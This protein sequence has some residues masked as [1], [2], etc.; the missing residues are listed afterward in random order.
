[1][2]HKYTLARA[3]V[4]LHTSVARVCTLHVGLTSTAPK[5]DAAPENA[6]TE[7]D[8]GFHCDIV[9]VGR[10]N[11]LKANLAFGSFK[12]NMFSRLLNDV[13]HFVSLMATKAILWP[14]KI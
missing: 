3:G 1:M 8:L 5:S 11:V 6:V 13:Q 7:R 4:A 2:Q 12:N 9:C 10:G 14:S